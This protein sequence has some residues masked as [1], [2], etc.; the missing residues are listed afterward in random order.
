MRLEQIAGLAFGHLLGRLMRRLA[1][2]LLV[3]ISAIVAIY[4]FTVAASLALETH[5][6]AVQAKLVVGAIYAGIA[7]VLAMVLWALRQRN[8]RVAPQTSLAQQ[9]EVQL[10]MLVEALMLG[11]GLAKK[12]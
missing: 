4:Q 8:N 6:D 3:I 11:Y 7:A 10:V 5:Y 9:R 2:M 1:L 12:R